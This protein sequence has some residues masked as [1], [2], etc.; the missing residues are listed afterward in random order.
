MLCLL[1]RTMLLVLTVPVDEFIDLK[2]RTSIYSGDSDPVTIA[3]ISSGA[4][5]L[6]ARAVYS[7]AANP[8]DKWAIESPDFV[9]R[10]RFTC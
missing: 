7:T 10:L 8:T 1:L 9:C 5:Y 3:D 2:S 6:Y 4:L